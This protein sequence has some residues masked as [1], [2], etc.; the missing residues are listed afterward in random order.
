VALVSV[1]N[2]V[3]YNALT[4]EEKEELMQEFDEHKATK[5]KALCTSTKSRV[6]DITH[7]VQRVEQEVSSSF[8]SR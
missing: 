2:R 4:V 1:E 6:S 7:A 3:K 8:A 5:G